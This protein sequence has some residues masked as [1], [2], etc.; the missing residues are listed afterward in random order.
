[1]FSDSCFSGDYSYFLSIG[2]PFQKKMSELHSSCYIKV[3]ISSPLRC[4]PK[5]WISLKY[6][7]F[8]PAPA[9]H[10]N[11]NKIMQ[12]QIPCKYYEI[13]VKG[14]EN[15]IYLDLTLSRHFRSDIIY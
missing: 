6:K 9:Y 10:Y 1:M 14:N 4:D 2:D 3:D 7:D 11:S 13:L 8:T 5:F 15:D 12:Y